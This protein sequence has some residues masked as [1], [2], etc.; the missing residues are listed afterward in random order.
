MDAFYNKPDESDKTCLEMQTKSKQFRN[1]LLN[2][3]LV[4]IAY[5]TDQSL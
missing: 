2:L 1:G 4:C 3:S 5:E